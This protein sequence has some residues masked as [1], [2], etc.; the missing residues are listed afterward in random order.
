MP[1]FSDAVD[2]ATVLPRG[3]SPP[4]A[5]P[6]RTR[7]ST[8]RL[9][10]RHRRMT[11]PAE[12]FGLSMPV[13]RAEVKGNVGVGP[14]KVLTIPTRLSEPWSGREDLN[15]RPLGPEPKVRAMIS[16]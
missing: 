12:R 4:V 10:S 5:K 15:L 3:G 7:A 2:R 8:D 9:A 1:D 16:K 13:R 6:P 14:S 11:A